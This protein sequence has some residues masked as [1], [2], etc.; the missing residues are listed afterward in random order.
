V[1]APTELEPKDQD[2]L[3]QRGPVARATLVAGGGFATSIATVLG[4]AGRYDLD[5]QAVLYG[6]GAVCLVSALTMFA[7][8]FLMKR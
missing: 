6:I 4:I 2:R 3:D 1:A 7:V 5:D 8:A